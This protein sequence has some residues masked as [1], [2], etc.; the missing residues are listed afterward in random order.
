MENKN[1][2]PSY[3]Q[4]LKVLVVD[5]QEYMRTV[6]GAILRGFG[7]HNIE[8]Y[9]DASGAYEVLKSFEGPDSGR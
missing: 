6:L 8:A 7:I 3:F 5:D 1:P 2:P 9:P 4:D